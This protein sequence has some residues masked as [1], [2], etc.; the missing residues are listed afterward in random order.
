MIADKKQSLAEDWGSRR[1]CVALRTDV[2]VEAHSECGV[3]SRP[4]RLTATPD[5]HDAPSP[6]VVLAV[7][8]DE[9]RVLAA[10]EACERGR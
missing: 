4:P 1:R 8:R 6:H 3:M 2:P 5:G 10:F 9:D 7:S